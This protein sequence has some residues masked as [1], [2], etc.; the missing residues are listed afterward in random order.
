MAIDAALV[1]RQVAALNRSID[2]LVYEFY[3]LTEDEIVTVEAS[4][5]R[6][7]ASGIA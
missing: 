6:P 7:I 5:E 1:D 3:G 2:V 4:I